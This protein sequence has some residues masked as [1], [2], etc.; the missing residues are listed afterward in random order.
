MLTGQAGEASSPACYTLPP[1]IR[2]QNP[3]VWKNQARK[4]MKFALKFMQ[5]RFRAG[6]CCGPAARYAG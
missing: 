1:P 2:A 3:P 4:T 6:N 5:Q